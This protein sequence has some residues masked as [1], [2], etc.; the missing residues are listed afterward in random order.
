MADTFEVWSTRLF[1]KGSGA[2]GYRLTGLAARCDWVVLS[3]S[4]EPRTFLRVR[5]GAPPSPRTL[6]LSMRNAEAA[7]LH[8]AEAVLPRIKSDFVLFSGSEDL[9]L[10]RQVDQRWQ[11]YPAPVRAAIDTILEH[12]HLKTWWA[13]NLDEAA[14]S[15]LH[16]MPLGLLPSGGGHA[17]A[18]VVEFEPLNRRPLSVL[19]AHRVR[20]GPQWEPRRKVTE[21][22]RNAWADWTTVLEEAVEPPIF[23][24]LLSR[25]SFV[26]CV[27]GGGLDPSPKAWQALLQGAIPIIRKSPTAE[28]YRD[29]PV[30]MI[31]DWTAR[32]ITRDKLEAWREQISTTYQQAA[33]WRQQWV[34]RLS[35]ER[36][37][38]TR[39]EPLGDTAHAIR[40][41][42]NK[43]AADAPPLPASA[44]P[45]KTATAAPA[46]Q[47]RPAAT[48]SSGRLPAICL[49]YDACAHET[50]FMLNS[51]ARHADMSGLEFF[52]P[53]NDA[54][55]RDVY[56]GEIDAGIAF[57][58]VKSPAPIAATLKALLDAVPDTR[59]VFW[60]TSDRY[61][62][63]C[64]DAAI[65]SHLAGALQGAPEQVSG[66]Q[67]VRLTRWGDV[68]DLT[69]T[70]RVLAGTDFEEG[71]A[72]G[73][74]HW[75]HQF[76]L[77]QCLEKVAETCSADAGLWDFHDVMVKTFTADQTGQSGDRARFLLP[78]E[79]IVKLEE[80][81]LEGRFTTNFHVR[82]L[83]RGEQVFPERLAPESAGYASPYQHAARN[84]GWPAEPSRLQA[85]VSDP[86]PPSLFQV[87]SP[88]G[89]GSKMV[90]RW[91]EPR[92]TERVW[93][94]M[95]S[96]RRLPPPAAFNAQKFIYLFGDPRNIV[97]SLFNRRFG[98][99][100][101]HGFTPKGD[102]AGRQDPEFVRKH[103]LNM[104]TDPSLIDASWD[105]QAYL[106]NGRDLLRLEE[107]FDSWFHG[108]QPYPVVF[109][110][111]ESLSDSGPELAR[112]LGI[113]RPP[114]AYQPRA[115]DW[116][117]L[118]D[119]VRQSLDAIYGDLARRLEALPDLVI[120]QQGRTST[121]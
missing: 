98:K 37:W 83:H 80:P 81:T 70:R 58:C 47:P 14:H 46:I 72:A 107:H 34:D 79:N 82:R 61:P 104:Q 48:R 52:L 20:T 41:S 43:P 38:N 65:L 55:T 17:M 10:P 86:P 103:A 88:G 118:P 101:R 11:T 26:L 117:A 105:L 3:D 116:Q 87:V 24:R 102:R 1:P 89:V 59:W 120:R 16:P 97:L 76:I 9:T 27:E 111:Y 114:I 4:A 91:L 60:T 42:A 7:I 75:H 33:N 106:E 8:F 63:M 108:D 36:G 57:Q 68:R 100:N 45:K 51:Y 119:K 96:H 77:R 44:Q 18:E 19:C 49:T 56:Q 112:W 15:K 25:H 30:V 84:A 93:S 66:I 28:A 121:P 21:L 40:L 5:P 115:S 35:F 23:N 29:F 64:A 109:A 71:R 78:V 113:R 73:Q 94:G 54:A 69:G 39:I 32:N 74:G 2:K 99:S 67:S 53:Y 95:H 90:T 110:R 62:Y 13:E 50:I 6:F 85:A 92:A 22:A 12:S 31:D